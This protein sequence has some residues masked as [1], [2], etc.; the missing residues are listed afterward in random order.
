[1]A[2]SHYL[3]SVTFE[4]HRRHN[5]RRPRGSTTPIGLAQLWSGEQVALSHKLPATAGLDRPR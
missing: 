2:Q 3:I 4:S 1:V 5:P